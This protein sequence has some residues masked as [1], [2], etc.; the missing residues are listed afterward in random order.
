MSLTAPTRRILLFA[1]LIITL[2]MGVRHSFGLFLAPMSADF[3]W[4]RE[5]FAFALAMQNL[6][7]GAAQ[8][9]AGAIA[10]RYGARRV[11]WAGTLCYVLGLLLMSN[12][13]T[14]LGLNASTGLLIGL[15][16][17]GTTYGVVFG[18]VGKSVPASHRS[19]A[20]GI[21]AAAGSLGQF[22]MLPIGQWSIGL[23]GWATTLMLFA[24]LLASM[25]PLS[26]PLVTPGSSRP[27]QSPWQAIGEALR[28]PGFLLLC[29]SYFVCG[30]QVTFVGVHLPAY[31]AD[32]GLSPT[33]GATALALIGLFNIAGTY[34]FGQLGAR[35][36]KAKLL[37]LIY[38]SRAVA[39]TLFVLAPL[40]PVS[41]MLFAAVIG[42]LWLATVPLTNGL[43]AGVFGV[44][45]LSMLGGF[46]FFS[47]QVGSFFGVWLGGRVFDA[48]GSY[49]P[50][51]WG[52]VV[53]G[54]VATFLALPIR[55][56]E[57]ARRA[58]A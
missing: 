41:A 47:H 32:Q 10:D 53:L 49:A 54:V 9:F 43:I 44:E 27:Q 5:T 19:Q 34:L 6:I 1:G 58:A 3:G 45:Y 7:W 17:A 16:L 37:A 55:E 35:R 33:V 13:S 28:H 42:F 11:L 24:F 14:A 21:V 31:L 57:L 8:P 25:A 12:A 18:V 20:M 4:G 23:V 30:F 40:T 39:I 38:A 56:V 15:G 2:A 29:A 51:W 52:S 36:D 48:I 26:I 50:V 22:L 46:A